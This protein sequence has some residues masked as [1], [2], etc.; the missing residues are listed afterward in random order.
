MT[1]PSASSSSPGAVAEHARVQRSGVLLANL[2]TPDE[3]T[4]P[5][6]RR[7]LR[8]FLSDR[9][10]VEIP[11]ALWWLIL[12]GFIL[13][14][15]PRR[16]A[17]AY[18]SVWTAEGSPLLAI[19]RAQQAGLQARLG[20]GG[21]DEVPVALGMRYGNPSIAS[22]IDDLVR[23]GARRIV[24]LPLYP[25]YSATTTASVFDAVLAR[26]QPMRWWPE[27]RFVN[28][29][30]D[31]ADYIAALADS[32]RAH[33]QRHGRGEH[34]LISFHSI[35]LNYLEAG[36]PYYCFCQKTARLL[37]EA[38]DLAPDVWSLSFQSRLGKAKWLSPYTDV[39]VERLGRSG[40]RTLDTICPGFSADCLETLEEVA[41]RYGEA[42]RAAGGGE[43]RYVA[44]L[45]AGE[46]HLD[47]LAALARDHLAGWAPAA[48]PD[49]HAASDARVALLR[50]GF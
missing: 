9:R 26:V 50:R 6:I 35:P 45:N 16:L 17:H 24:V 19:S 25:Q 42:F 13:P 33:W 40:V 38:L 15:R 44:A 20:G 30:H 43:L 5:A 14:F 10:V 39:T 31:R 47:L 18:Q 8:E 37:A 7:Y 27:L 21:H 3:P 28:G 29:Y 48:A 32:V 12:Y 34:L 46:R 49:A 41:L 1:V 36:D 23:R 4:A 2:G 11:R 22:A